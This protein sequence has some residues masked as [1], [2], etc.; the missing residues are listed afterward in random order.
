MNH[1]SVYAVWR[2][3]WVLPHGWMVSLDADIQSR[4]DQGTARNDRMW[5]MDVSV[6][7]SWL[8]GRLSVALQGSDLWNSRR[9]NIQLFGSRL[10]YSKVLRPDSRCFLLTVSYCFRLAGKAYR[11]KHAAEEDL[12]RL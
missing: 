7:R 3:N 12:Q 4:G 2:N 10:T 8:D 9:M 1:A 5:G 6:R 11:G